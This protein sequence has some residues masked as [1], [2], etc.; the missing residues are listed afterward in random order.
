MAVSKMT[1]AR[2]LRA[3]L[4]G[5]LQP[6]MFYVPSNGDITKV[7]VTRESVLGEAPPRVLQARGGRERSA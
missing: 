1:G 4:E 5:V 6:V 3:I 2:G 7:I